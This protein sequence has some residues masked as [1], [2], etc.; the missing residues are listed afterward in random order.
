MAEIRRARPEDLTALLGLVRAFYLVDAHDYDPDRVTAALRPMLADDSLGQVWVVDDEGGL[1]GY[2]IVTW[3]WS[4]ES[5]GRDCILDEIYVEEGGHGHGSALLRHALD[6]AR[7]FGALACFLE[8]EAPND[9]A[10]AFYARH[11]FVSE[12]SVWMSRPL[13]TPRGD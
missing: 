6:Q 1:T 2:A 10:R 5:G 4:L 12:Q 3:T 7:E 13:A 8:T 9:R 11:G